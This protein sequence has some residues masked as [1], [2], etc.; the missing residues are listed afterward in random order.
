MQKTRLG[1]T[2]GLVFPLSWAALSSLLNANYLSGLW[3]LLLQIPEGKYLNW[4]IK[5]LGSP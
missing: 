5:T 2:K 3:S 1:L 4:V